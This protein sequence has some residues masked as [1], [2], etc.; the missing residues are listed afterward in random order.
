MHRNKTVNPH[1]FA[2]I[3][4]ADIPRSA[5][6]LRKAYKTTF[7][8]GYLV[9]FFLEEA[10]PGDL[11]H[12]KFTLFARLATPQV[13][14]MDNLTLET[15]FFFVPNR[16][17]WPN[18][19]KMM[20]ERN[21]PDD[22]IDFTVPQIYFG[23]DEVGNPADYQQIYDY[24]GLPM[25]VD[26]DEWQVSALPFRMYNLIW[27]QWFRDENL[28]DS[29]SVPQT[30][31]PDGYNALTT[32]KLLRRG[33]RPDYFTGCLPFA[34]KGPAVQLPLGGTAPVR[35]TGMTLGL[36][37]G[38]DVNDEYGLGVFN[39]GD[40]LGGYTGVFGQPWGTA[41]SGVGPEQGYSLG[42]TTDAT[43]SGLVADLSSATAA[44]INAIRMS[45]QIQKLLERDARGGTRYTEI[46][47]SHFG[48]R[49]PDER[50]QRPEYLGGGNTPIVVNQVASTAGQ[51]EGIG[52]PTG[53]LGA[54]GKALGRHG[55]TR[56]IVEHG[57]IMGLLSVR[58]D[59]TYQQGCRRHWSRRTRYDFYFPVFAAL[60]E[61]AVLNKEIYA[62]G[63][64]DDE[65]VFGYQERWAEYRY[66]PSEV[67]GLM[68]STAPQPL[69][70][71]HLSQEFDA[72]PV[73]ND[74][75]IQDNPPVNRVLA[76]DNMAGT[77]QFLL[78]VFVDGS[79]VRNMP[80]YSVPGLVDHF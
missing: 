56:A 70:M 78:D 51:F 29:V 57:Y 38:T 68:R 5:F 28:Q 69:D 33:K 16:L 60:G 45:F 74:S 41:T 43:K 4:R 39:S 54:E 37:N 77:A 62:Q 71:W 9:P 49:S 67:T 30:D 40:E 21:D 27:N 42:V 59:L 8:G 47:F 61:Q 80:A 17:V 10:L 73:L 20:G 35:G 3:P 22:S 75:F 55:F 32:H 31:G 2:M 11:W 34:Q 36:Q 1:N 66:L 53:N 7:D 65:L 72:L 63:T 18:W 14:F 15:F 76:T 19:V 26:F 25:E 23:K 44:T 48:V 12:A 50:L 13:P 46:L 6:G 64:S 24:F 52:V 58:A 79:M